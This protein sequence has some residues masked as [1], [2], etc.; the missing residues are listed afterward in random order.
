MGSRDGD[1]IVMLKSHVNM[2]EVFWKAM[3]YA[4]REIAEWQ[5]AKL[6]LI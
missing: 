4:Q 3:W 1:I 2:W 5:V 6:S